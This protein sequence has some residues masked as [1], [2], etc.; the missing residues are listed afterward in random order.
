MSV[1]DEWDK[2]AN[3]ISVYTARAL[4]IESQGP[5]WFYGSGA[6][7]SALYQYQLY[8]AKDVR[9]SAPIPVL[10]YYRQNVN[11]MEIC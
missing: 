1:Y 2:T 11:I 9:E 7:H 8:K 4:L 6:E 3:Q 5:C 10:F